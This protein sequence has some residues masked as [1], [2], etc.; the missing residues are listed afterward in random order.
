MIFTKLEC[1][2]TKQTIK[3]AAH[4]VEYGAKQKDADNLV[5]YGSGNSKEHA[6]AS[7]G[8]SFY[9]YS[10]EIDSIPVKRVHISEHS[11][12]SFR[13]YPITY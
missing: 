9:I 2:R 1:K 5:Q 7:E 4:L 3:D 11:D 13:D 12:Q 10:N 8:H 6:K